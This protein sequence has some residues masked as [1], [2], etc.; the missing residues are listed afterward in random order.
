MRFLAVRQYAKLQFTPYA[1]YIFF[2]GTQEVCYNDKL[3][4][5]G[6]IPLEE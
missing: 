5:Y 1:G 4:D 6:E 2:D 3:K